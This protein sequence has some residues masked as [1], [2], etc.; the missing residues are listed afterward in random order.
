MPFSNQF[1]ILQSSNSSYRNVAV[2]WTT[3]TYNSLQKTLNFSATTI[4]VSFL[5][6]NSNFSIFFLF[7]GDDFEVHRR[8]KR[9]VT[10]A[11]GNRVLRVVKRDATEM[12]EVETTERIIQVYKK[13]R[14]I[15]GSHSIRKVM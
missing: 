3:A 5:T 7:Q 12:A 4:S 15:I 6:F 14:E 13:Y 11:N 8:K 9:Q 1:Q 10:D 2:V